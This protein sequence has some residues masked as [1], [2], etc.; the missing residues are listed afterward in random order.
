MTR[1]VEAR[2]NF[3]TKEL[4][5]FPAP[6]K[7]PNYVVM[8]SIEQFVCCL[9]SHINADSDDNP[10]RMEFDRLALA[11]REQLQASKL[12][13]GTNLTSDQPSDEASQR[14]NKS[15]KT[16]SKKRDGEPA[17]CK[18][19]KPDPFKAAVQ[20]LTYSLAD[21]QTRYDRG[22][23][24]SIPGSINDKVTEQLIRESC[25]GWRHIV[26]KLLG[27]M[28]SFIRGMIKDAMEEALA[29]WTHVKF[30]KAM[31]QA[32]LDYVKKIMAAQ[33]QEIHKHLTR[34]H[35]YPTTLD[36]RFGALE[37]D[38]LKHL[39]QKRYP[40]SLENHL[41]I[42]PSVL[43]PGFIPQDQLAADLN[44]A[45]YRWINERL[46]GDEYGRMISCVAKV[47]TFHDILSCNLADTATMQLKY[48]VLEQ[49]Q[50]EA[51]EMLR[52]EL[53]VL[54][55]AHCTALLAKD[56]AREKRRK[57]LVAEKGKLTQ[58]LAVVKDL[59][60]TE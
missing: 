23:T 22:A 18:R 6:P 46:T 29:A 45:A 39:L 34:M 30:F 9:S 59:E 26:E 13:V 36:K 37:K 24:N 25:A 58:A 42:T 56:P 7:E 8:K 17:S 43:T 54:D 53:R 14:Q 33:G 55:T 16:Q 12:E 35:A 1:R 60:D 50:D 31:K 38:H 10:F 5:Q 3:V 49:L 40:K 52:T 19:I 47:H 57:Q 20:K 28:E 11:F 4:D 51:A 44:D 27:D 41:K 32:A 2:I 15:N 48:D 21:L